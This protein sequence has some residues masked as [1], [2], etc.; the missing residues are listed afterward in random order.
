MQRRPTGERSTTLDLHGQ[1]RGL[2]VRDVDFE[3]GHVQVMGWGN[4]FRPGL[5][6]LQ[7]ERSLV[8]FPQLREIVHPYWPRR[9]AEAGPDALLFP[10]A[11]RDGHMI[12]DFRKALG[13]V[14]KT[15]GLP[16]FRV[17][18]LRHTFASHALQL[19]GGYPITTFDVAKMLGHTTSALVEDRYGHL[20]ADIVQRSEVVEYRVEHFVHRPAF[21]AKLTAL[22]ERACVTD[23]ATVETVREILSRSQH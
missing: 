4:P 14:L 1:A 12:T 19:R 15:C 17:H 22:Y 7:S 5:K 9:L 18:D 16:T 2:L 11:K 13:F 6:T 8:I 10:Q 23:V 21:H 3:R 20:L